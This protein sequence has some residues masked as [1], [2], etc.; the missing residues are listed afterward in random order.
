MPRLDMHVV[1]SHVR[2]FARN[3]THRNV[4]A[5]YS[6]PG[7]QSVDVTSHPLVVALVNGKGGTGKTTVAM[8]LAATAAQVYQV[9]LVDTDRQLSAYRLHTAMREQPYRC[10]PE[11]R[12]QFL[13]QLRDIPGFD[14]ILLDTAGNLESDDIL[15]P[16]LRA[17][18]LTVIPSSM[19]AMT[20]EPTMDTIR[21]VQARGRPFMVL[22]SAMT[23]TV[24]ERQARDLFAR[25]EIPVCAAR[26]RRLVA[27]EQAVA[28]GVP[29]TMMPGEYAGRAKVDLLEVFLELQAV[30]R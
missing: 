9:L 22:L 27:H 23:G 12:P 14:M 8:G 21:F 17:A 13:A 26:V 6:R 7:L 24:A 29:I 30:S 28:E 16:V 19:S 3:I 2:T 18:D 25:L 20:A 5:I 15:D 10:V 4:V 1:W 11:R